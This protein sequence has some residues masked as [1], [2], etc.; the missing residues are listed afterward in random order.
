MPA[1]VRLRNN[2]YTGIERIKTNMDGG[3]ILYS[4]DKQYELSFG[5]YKRCAIQCKIIGIIN[6][7][8]FGNCLTYM[9]GNIGALKAGNCAYMQLLSNPQSAQISNKSEVLQRSLSDYIK[10]EESRMKFVRGNVKNTPAN[11]LRIEGSLTDLIVV[12]KCNVEFKVELSGGS[13]EYCKVSNNVYFRGNVMRLDVEN[14]AYF[15]KESQ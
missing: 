7:A 11:I 12:P 8:Y 5:N 14:C 2:Y 9:D 15:F 6:K 4:K 1:N 13:I 3:I 10:S